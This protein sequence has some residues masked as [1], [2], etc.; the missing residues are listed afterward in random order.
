MIYFFVIIGYTIRITNKN[1]FGSSFWLEHLP[2]TQEVAGSSPVQTEPN[3]GCS[4]AVAHLFWE[5][6]VAG[7][8]PVI[9][10]W[11]VGRVVECESLENF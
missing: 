2:V 8:N 4:A 6:G 1:W 3:T 7:S 11:K 5:Q 9:P 10:I